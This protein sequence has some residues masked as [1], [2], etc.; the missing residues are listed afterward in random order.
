MRLMTYFHLSHSLR[1]SSQPCRLLWTITTLNW[2]KL[3]LKFSPVP[4]LIEENLGMRLL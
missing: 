1:L 3:S 4:G 2:G